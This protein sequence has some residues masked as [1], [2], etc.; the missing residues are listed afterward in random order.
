MR[1]VTAAWQIL[2]HN[3]VNCRWTSSFLLAGL[4]F[5]KRKKKTQSKTH[6]H[7]IQ[8]DMAKKKPRNPGS[9]PGLREWDGIQRKR[10]M[11]RPSFCNFYYNKNFTL[12]VSLMFSEIQI[13]KDE[14]FKGTHKS[15]KKCVFHLGT[16]ENP[17]QTGLQA[18]FWKCLLYCTDLTVAQSSLDEGP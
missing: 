5:K 17:T 2:K 1:S 14:I 12:H 4:Y 13:S 9:C 8:P 3:S 10:R 7:Y 11:D 6:S 18:S 16:F 15:L